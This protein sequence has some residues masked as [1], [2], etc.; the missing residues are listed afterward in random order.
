MSP[1]TLRKEGDPTAV[2]LSTRFPT[3]R[4]PNLSLATEDA[5][6]LIAYIDAMTYAAQAAAQTAAAG[7]AGSRSFGPQPLGPR[8]LGP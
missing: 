4:M 8:S 5:G 2:A 7:R 1:E 6:D 3:V